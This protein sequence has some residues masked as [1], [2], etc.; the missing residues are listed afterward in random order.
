M[1]AWSASMRARQLAITRLLGFTRSRFSSSTRPCWNRDPP[2]SA[3]TVLNL[4]L[5]LTQ[6]L[7]QAV[8]WGYLASNPPQAA[9]CPTTD[10][11]NLFSTATAD[12][13]VYCDTIACFGY[14]YQQD[15]GSGLCPK[16]LASRV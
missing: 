16:T 13:K 7:G 6:V 3:G 8:K 15:F 14:D 12:S 1:S 11:R 10:A 9:A 5:V 4:H 2:L